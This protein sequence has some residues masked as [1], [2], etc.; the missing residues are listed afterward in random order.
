[1]AA[2]ALTLAATLQRKAAK[3]DLTAGPPADLTALVTAWHDAPSAETAGALL[4][5]AVEAMRAHGVDAETALRARA[6]A[7][8]DHLIA[9][10][11]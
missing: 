3:L 4:W 7:V 2:P 11:Q 1:M 9:A 5:A 10:E 6:R 8:R